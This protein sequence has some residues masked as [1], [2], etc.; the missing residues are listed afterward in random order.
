[1]YNSYGP[2]GTTVK[3]ADVVNE[4]FHPCSNALLGAYF[5]KENQAV[6][7]RAGLPTGATEVYMLNF[8]GQGGGPKFLRLLKQNPNA[9]ATPLFEKEA[10]YNPTIFTPTA[11]LQTVY[12]TMN[13]KVGA[14]V[15]QWAEYKNKQLTELI[16]IPA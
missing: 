14:T 9:L 10:R 1:M 8:L 2:N 15:P 4:V 11:T 12:N 13:R 6:L 3:N 16:G 7:A 5:V